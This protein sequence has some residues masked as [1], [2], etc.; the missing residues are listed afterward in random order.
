MTTVLGAIA[1]MLVIGGLVMLVAGLRRVPTAPSGPRTTAGRTAGSSALSARARQV[2]RRTR[3]LLAF[4]VLFG[5]IVAVTTGWIL[6]I[7]LLPLAVAGL[8]ILLAPTPQT[9]ILRLEALEEWT[10]SLAGVL[11]AG[12]GL[13]QALIVTLRSTPAP[14]ES[15]VSTLVGRLHARWPTEEAL[16]AF[17]DDLD[18]A[19]GDLIAAKLALAARRRGPGL[20][21]VLESLAESVAADVQARRAVEADRDK[22]RATVRWITVI[23]VAALALLALNTTYITPYG[24]PLGQLLLA[25]LLG[26]DVACL[27]W[28]RAMTRVRPAPRFIGRSVNSAQLTGARTP[29]GR[30]EP[31]S[32]GSRS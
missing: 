3:L 13:E 28:M 20:A 15:E 10:R 6:A 1:G 32:S 2:S 17:A 19:T 31:V 23:T 4:G 26:I 30:S 11:T 12:A 27:T 24:S 18:D 9:E 14:I 25:V 16:R 8:P 22:P 29:A 7:V 5:V 21:S